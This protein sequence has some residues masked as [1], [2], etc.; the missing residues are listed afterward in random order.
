MRK[1]SRSMASAIAMTA[2]LMAS[3]TGSAIA[4]D[5]IVDAPQQQQRIARSETGPAD[6]PRLPAGLDDGDAVAA[7]DG[8]RIALTEVGDGGSYVWHR[9]DGVLSGMAQPT[10]SYK[11]PI[12]QPCR[13]LIVMLNTY[14]RTSRIEGTACRS[15]AGRWLL[16]N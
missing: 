11:D 9:R 12:G 5:E 10:S 6:A 15:T 7:L 16:E 13:N 3:N 8:I 2:G 14:G 4:G 1:F